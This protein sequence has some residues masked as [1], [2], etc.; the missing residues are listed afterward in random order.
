MPHI[1]SQ[2]IQLSKI[3][4]KPKIKQKNCESCYVTT[5]HIVIYGDKHICHHCLG[6]IR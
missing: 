5:K 1:T 4:A 2:R 3:I 6:N